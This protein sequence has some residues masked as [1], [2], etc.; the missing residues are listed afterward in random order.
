M[1]YQFKTNI[2]CAHCIAKVAPFLNANTE[3]KSWE[4]DIEN[5]DKI[6]TID[7]EL[8]VEKV[9]EIAREAGYKAE[10]VG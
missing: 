4:V 2:M 8:P 6:L 10:I 3:I 9:R 1:R 7:T 5:P